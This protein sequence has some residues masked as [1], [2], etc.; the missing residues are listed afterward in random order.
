MPFFCFSDADAGALIRELHEEISTENIKFICRVKT[1]D[2][3][4]IS[5]LLSDESRG[6]YLDMVKNGSSGNAFPFELIVYF[7]RRF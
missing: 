5:Q 1:F 6:V 7:F 4:D 3:A 2:L